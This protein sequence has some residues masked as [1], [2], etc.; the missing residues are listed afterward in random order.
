MNNSLR[1]AHRFL[2]AAALLL[3][4]QLALAGAPLKGIDVKLGKNPGGGCANRTTGADGKADFGV[5]PKG[6]YTLEFA[7]A[8][9]AAAPASQATGR[10]IPMPALMKV[11]AVIS[12][13]TTGRMER[14]FPTGQASGRVAP[15]EFTL[16]GKQ[17]LVVVVSA[18][19]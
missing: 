6:N 3:G 19:D 12:G 5:W 15:L 7:P 2:P 14:D 8:A 13:A 11:H 18:G 17:S 9:A 4:A 10:T 1:F 16:D